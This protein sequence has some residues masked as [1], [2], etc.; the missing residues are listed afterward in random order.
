MANVAE[1]SI[2]FDDLK[3]LNHELNTTEKKVNLVAKEAKKDFKPLR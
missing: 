2:K 1:F 3:E